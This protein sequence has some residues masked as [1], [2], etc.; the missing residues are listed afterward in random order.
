M[1]RSLLSLLILALAPAVA[2]AGNYGDKVPLGRPLPLAEALAQDPLPSGRVLLSGRITEVCQNKGCW[3]MLEDDGVA[4]RLKMHDHAF[5]IPKDYRGRSVV[6]GEL[7]RVEMAPEQAQH[8]AEEAGRS[9]P[10][11]LA[12]YHVDTL[13]L[14]LVDEGDGHGR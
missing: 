2:G 4:A 1:N 10:D 9:A 7:A 3:A 8:Y 11:S 5:F 13:G 12:E 14:D 6:W